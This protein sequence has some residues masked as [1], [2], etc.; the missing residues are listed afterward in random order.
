MTGERKF[1][2]GSFGISHKNEQSHDKKE[3]KDD[4][5]IFVVPMDGSDASLQAVAVASFEAKQSKKHTEVFLFHVIE[6]GWHLALDAELPDQV[7]KADM[8]LDKGETVALAFGIKPQRDILQGRDVA[9]V[10][11]QD[12]SELKAARIFIGVDFKKSLD[13]EIG[14]PEPLGAVANEIIKRAE[15]A[16]DIIRGVDPQ[17]FSSRSS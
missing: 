4:P 5:V 11:V 9:H 13:G 3:N 6:V 1:H 2:P 7:D 17:R 16:V 10:I 12:A 14:R 8:I 15:C